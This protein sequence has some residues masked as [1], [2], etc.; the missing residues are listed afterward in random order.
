[1]FNCIV[2]YLISYVQ[3]EALKLRVGIEA[4]VFMVRGISDFTMAPK[5]FFTSP[6]AEQF[7]RLYLCK[8]IAQLATDFES[9]ILASGLL[10]SE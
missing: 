9:T 2:R 7:V 6:A 5:A 4:M 1:M 8:D 10:L 3:L